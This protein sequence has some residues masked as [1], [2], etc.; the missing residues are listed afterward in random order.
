MKFSRFLAA[1]SVGVVAPALAL[2]LPTRASADTCNGFIFIEYPN[3]MGPVNIGD[4][5]DVRIFLAAGLIQGGPQNVLTVTDFFFNLAC[6]VDAQPISPFGNGIGPGGSATGCV[7]DPANPVSFV[8]GSLANVTCGVPF[9]DGGPGFGDGRRIDTPGLVL[10]GALVPVFCSADFKV[11]VNA[12]SGDSTPLVIEQLVGYHG[13]KCDSDTGFLDSGNFQT[14]AID[15][16]PPTP[17]DFDCYQADSIFNGTLNSLTDVFGTFTNVQVAGSQRLCTP[18][19]KVTDPAEP[20]NLPQ[21]P[22]AHLVGYQLKGSFKRHVLGVHVTTMQFGDFTVDV[23]KV[24]GKA[25]LLVPSSKSLD[26]NNPPPNADA[27]TGH[28]LCYNF[29]TVS[30]GTPKPVLVRDQFNPNPP[31]TKPPQ[32]VTFTNQSSWQL[33]VPV[34][35]NGEDPSAETSTS[36]LL[37]LVTGKDINSPIKPGV[38]VSWS[39]QLQP[40]QKRVHLD[41]L[42]DFCVSATITP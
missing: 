26:P 16:V 9:S 34:D 19:V 10:H 12:L 22:S 14:A 11:Q 1:V 20:V 8:A 31:G 35:K 13:A 37:C 41:K 39:N 5:V 33:C 24:S 23:K 18:A 36:G 29:D 21:D 15:I 27:K 2:L 32:T 3:L 40:A 30:G 4:Q 38:R 42:D 28:F 17:V 7:K 6:D 25:A